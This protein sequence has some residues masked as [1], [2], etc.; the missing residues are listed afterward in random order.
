[1]AIEVKKKLNIDGQNHKFVGVDL[2]FSKSD[3][4]EGYFKSTSITTAAVKNNIRM[5]MNTNKGERLMQ[6]TLGLSLERFL[7]EQITSETETIIKDDIQQAFLYWL[8]FVTINKLTII[9]GDNNENQLK[10]NI[11]FFINNVPNM[12]DSVELIFDGGEI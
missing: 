11:E 8:P 2:P 6:P 10:V 5:L 9:K 1:M 7:F 3:G 4:V 12:L